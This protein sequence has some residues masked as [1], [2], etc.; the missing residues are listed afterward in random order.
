MYAEW[1]NGEQQRHKSR[2][3]FQQIDAISFHEKGLKALLQNM[4]LIHQTFHQNFTEN[5]PT[6]P[7]WNVMHFQWKYE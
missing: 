1:T 3:S 7:W 2:L 6:P 4:S 5:G